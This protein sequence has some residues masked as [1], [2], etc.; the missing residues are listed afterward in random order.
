MFID[1][2]KGEREEEKERVADEEEE[3]EEDEEVGVSSKLLLELDSKL[4]KLQFAIY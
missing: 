4:F 1:E 2:E 3:E